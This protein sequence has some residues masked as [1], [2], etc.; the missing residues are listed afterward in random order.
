MST[1]VIKKNFFK[2]EKLQ[3]QHVIL[4]SLVLTKYIFFLMITSND[5]E[6]FA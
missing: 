2:K 4:R 3:K 6:M 1:A 5:C